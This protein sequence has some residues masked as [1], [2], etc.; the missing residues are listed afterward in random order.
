MLSPSRTMGPAAEAGRPARMSASA[1][2]DQT[3]KTRLSIRMK[4]HDT[5]ELSILIY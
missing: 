3:A 1:T 2:N 4:S 5:P